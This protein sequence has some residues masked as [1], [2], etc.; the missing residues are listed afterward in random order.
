MLPE[1]AP[2]PRPSNRAER[3]VKGRV[4]A[5]GRVAIDWIDDEL[6]PRTAEGL[7]VDESELG[8]GLLTDTRFEP[9]TIVRIRGLRGETQ[10]AV[11]RHSR[12]EREFEWRTGLRLLPIESRAAEREP[13]G[14]AARLAWLDRR[15]EERSIE[16][17]VRD[18]S[19]T[20]AGLDSAEPIEPGLFARMLGDE[21]SCYCNVRHCRR[22]ERGRY[23]IGVRFARAPENRTI[24]VALEWID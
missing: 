1:P 19:E 11:V 2:A 16:V 10:R 20:G 14:G 24:G 23:L 3:R 4:P 13:V 9:G 15:G 22:S 8:L 18:L 21:F 6:G 12:H 7:A 5:H 17:L